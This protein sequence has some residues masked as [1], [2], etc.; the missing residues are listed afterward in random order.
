M[1]GLIPGNASGL[2]E[3]TR[4]APMNR[5][6]RRKRVTT[7]DTVLFESKYTQCTLYLLLLRPPPCECET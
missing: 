3:I 6:C 1:S 2:T 4:Y 5:A 7:M